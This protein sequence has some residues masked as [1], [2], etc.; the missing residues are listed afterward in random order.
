MKKSVSNGGSYRIDTHN[1]QQDHPSSNLS[2]VEH[3]SYDVIDSAFSRAPQ[4]DS[5]RAPT[6]KIILK[7]TLA[8]E[9]LPAQHDRPLKSAPSSLDR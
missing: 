3:S 2:L 4:Y 9:I 6:E 8:A 7:D 1:T 5:P